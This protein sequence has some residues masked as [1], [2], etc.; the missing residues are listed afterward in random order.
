M[1]LHEQWKNRITNVKTKSEFYG[2]IKAMADE[3]TE[4]ASNQEYA[5]VVC[6]DEL[7]AIMTSKLNSLFTNIEDWM[8]YRQEV[9]NKDIT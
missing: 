6:S 7:N 9:E 2:V 8:R 1:T 4:N 3:M 5:D